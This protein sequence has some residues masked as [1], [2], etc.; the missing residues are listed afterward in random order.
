MKKALIVNGIKIRDA[1][2]ETSILSKVDSTIYF[3]KDFVCVGVHP[4]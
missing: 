4:K 2:E 3:L 1:N